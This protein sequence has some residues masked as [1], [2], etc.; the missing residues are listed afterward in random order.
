VL[1]QWGAGQDRGSG[2]NDGFMYVQEQS[3]MT[4]DIQ[5][6]PNARRQARLQLVSVTSTALP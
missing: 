2:S 1:V 3:S 4:D 6:Q 5:D